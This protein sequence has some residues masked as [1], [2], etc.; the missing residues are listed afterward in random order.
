MGLGIQIIWVKVPALLV[1]WPQAIYL[2]SLSLRFLVYKMWAIIVLVMLDAGVR[3]LCWG[4]KHLAFVSH[5]TQ[6]RCVFHSK[7]V[8]ST[9]QQRGLAVPGYSAV[10]EDGDSTQTKVSPPR[11]YW[12]L[13]LVISLLWAVVVFIVEY[14]TTSMAFTNWMSIVTPLHPQL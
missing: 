4:D 12:H 8:V 2:P 3:S 13:G 5:S 11:S 9:H 10:Q 1:V 6:Q 7:L 14:S